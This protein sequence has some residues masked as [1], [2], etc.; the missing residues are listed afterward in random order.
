MSL[1]WMFWRRDLLSARVKELFGDAVRTRSHSTIDTQQLIKKKAL[2][3]LNI[4]SKVCWWSLLLGYATFYLKGWEKWAFTSSCNDGG[5]SEALATVKRSNLEFCRTSQERMANKQNK[6]G[7]TEPYTG[8][9]E[10]QEKLTGSKLTSLLAYIFINSHKLH[11]P[12]S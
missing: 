3:F 10:G 1:L 9:T 6:S 8:W 11:K 7:R 5:S 2:S 12:F 4:F